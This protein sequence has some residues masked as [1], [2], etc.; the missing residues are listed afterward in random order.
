MMKKV[1]VIGQYGEGPDYTTGQA[2][3]TY[4]T[5][6]WLMRRFGREQVVIVNTYGWKKRPVRLFVSLV[7]AM[8]GCANAIIFPAQHGVKV[9]PLAVSM[10]NRF[11]HR[12]TF[13][14]VIGGWLADFLKDHPAIHRAVASFDG[15]CAETE[16]LAEQLK[17]IG[18][19]HAWHLPNCRD[20]LA[21]APKRL[22]DALPLKVC[23][24]SRVTESKGIADAAAICR[25][26]N[27]TLGQRVFQLEV[28]GPVASEY[29]E[30]FDRLCAREGENLRYCG[31]RNADEAA[32]VLSGQFALLFP[33]YYEGECF[34]GTALDAFQSRTPI[35]A[36]DWK[37]N[38]EV[39]ADGENGFLYPFRDT[40]AAAQKLVSLYRDKTLYAHIQEG[41]ERS[42]RRYDSDAVL[43][44]LANKMA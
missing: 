1:A 12:R 34:A 6:Q 19:P 24:Y 2:V 8:A 22:P 37:Y 23:T 41:C 30:E 11:F 28:Y 10:L 18:I 21:A 20:Y 26:A 38:G 33:T 16:S 4:F 25:K 14:V 9:F 42:A 44:R 39:I 31:V 32:S 29:K 15:V 3:K 7:R 36:N 13:F 35:I 5:A 43:E 27:E 17:A 40:D